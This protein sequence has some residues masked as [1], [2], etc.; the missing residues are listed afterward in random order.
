MPKKNSIDKLSKEDKEFLLAK[1]DIAVEM[2]AILTEGREN[3]E[4]LIV[5]ASALL[6]LTPDTFEKLRKI[7]YE[8]K[9]SSL[10]RQLW[11]VGEI[12]GLYDRLKEEM[13]EASYNRYDIL[14]N[15]D[16]ECSA[17]TGQN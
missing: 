14:R 3:Q 13:D 11:Q 15:K 7:L 4:L 2:I 1:A 16:N 6:C 8:Q 10:Y 12:P 5:D 9:D 17:V